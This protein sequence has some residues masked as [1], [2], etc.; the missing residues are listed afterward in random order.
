[1]RPEN[2]F[3]RVQVTIVADCSQLLPPPSHD[4]EAYTSV[5][6]STTSTAKALVG[7]EKNARKDSIRSSVAS[8][9]ISRRQIPA[10]FKIMKVEDPPHKPILRLLALVMP[11]SRMGW[12]ECRYLQDPSKPSHST[13]SVSPFWVCARLTRASKSLNKPAKEDLSSKLAV[14]MDTGHFRCEGWVLRSPRWIM[15]R[16]NGERL[17]SRIPSSLTE[18]AI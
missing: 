16:A 10:V 3:G 17:G 8:H 13:R 12:S 15:W 7:L 1:M 5:F 14:G 2:K 9:I 6:S 18:L 11:E 4:I